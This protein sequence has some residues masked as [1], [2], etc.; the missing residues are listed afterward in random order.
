MSER[1][2][3]I[4]P[5]LWRVERHWEKYPDVDLRVLLRRLGDKKSLPDDKTLRDRLF[6]LYPVKG[7]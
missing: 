6:E 2:D 4:G 3:R 5:I 1:S 7:A